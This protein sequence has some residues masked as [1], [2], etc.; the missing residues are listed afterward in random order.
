MIP[1]TGVFDAG[2]LIAFHQ[3]D[4]VRWL[5]QLFVQAFVPPEVAREVQPSF[6][7]LPDWIKI[8]RAQ[9]RLTYPRSLGAGERAAIALAMDLSADFVV[10][11]DRRARSVATDYGL[12]PI[13]SLGLLIRAKRIGLT[14]EVRP[15]MDEV[16]Q[17]GL[18]VSEKVYLEILGLSGEYPPHS[19]PR[20][21][22][23]A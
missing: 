13:G 10:T 19:A 18:F 5:D 2:P 7:E 12:T 17:N 4:R 11:D 15:L 8:E 16:I 14:T 23:R 20:H 6:G 21:P 22:R 3:I 9:A 1:D